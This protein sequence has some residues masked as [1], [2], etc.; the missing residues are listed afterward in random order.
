LSIDGLKVVGA[1]EDGRVRL[2]SIKEGSLVGQPWEG[3][4]DRVKCLDW[5]PNGAEVAGGLDDGTIQRWNTSS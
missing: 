1:C 4:N 2:W 3:N 5:S